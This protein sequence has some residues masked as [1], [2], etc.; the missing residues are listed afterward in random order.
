MTEITLVSDGFMVGRNIDDPNYIRLQ[1]TGGN[2]TFNIIMPI[3]L[4][5]NVA[6][7]VD[8]ATVQ[9]RP[10]PIGADEMKLGAVFRPIARQVRSVSGGGK[11]LVLTVE[12]GDGARTIPIELSPSEVADLISDLSRA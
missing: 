10:Q 3:E 6:Q 9:S 8:N 7:E 1:F 12:M 5:Q 2:D 4:G 11:R